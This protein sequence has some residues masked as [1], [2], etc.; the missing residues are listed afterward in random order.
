MWVLGIEFGPL[1]KQPALLSLSHLFSLLAG[2]LNFFI[3]SE[4]VSLCS[5]AL[6]ELALWTRLALNSEIFACLCL[7]SAGIKG[8]HHHTHS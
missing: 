4:R 5:L 7:Q 3:F 2:F 8:V 6:L 1:E